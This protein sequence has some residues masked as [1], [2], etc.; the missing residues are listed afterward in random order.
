MRAALLLMLSCTSLLPSTALAADAG[1]L[2]TVVMGIAGRRGVDDAALTQALSR[3][4]LGEYAKD[5]TRVVIGPDDITRVLEW[6][7]SRQQAGCD[8]NACLAEVGAA[9][10]A[11][12]IV[13]GTLDAVGNIYL[14]S[15]SEIDARTLEPSGRVQEEVPKDEAKLLDATRRLAV[16]L[17]KKSGAT[18]ASSGGT[19]VG[20]AGS[21]EIVSDPNGAQILVSNNVLGTTPTKI[22]NVAPG[23]HLVRLTRNDYES[24]EVEVPVHPGGVTKVNAELRIVRSLAEKNI[25]I[26][27]TRWREADQNNT[28]FGWSKVAFGAVGIGAGLAVMV[29]GRGDGLVPGGL[30]AGVGTGLAA[31]GAVD[32]LNPPKRPIPEW[33]I[34][35][36][37]TVTPP[38][39]KGEVEVKVLQE[40]PAS[41]M[42][43]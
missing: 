36:K 26:R 4:V 6:E 22:D 40:A 41:T 16:D 10:D 18:L 33:E 11:A 31:W 42:T 7:A 13:N 25:E 30:I 27:N 20:N 9:L 39:D 28:I 23:R 5:P 1:R 43:R 32:V 38:K 29:A 14:L 19:F 24:V 17:M 8:D 12:R 37:V 3:V 2:R 34:E 35:R 21:I 15:L